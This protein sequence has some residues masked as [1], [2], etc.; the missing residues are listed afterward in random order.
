MKRVL[1]YFLLSTVIMSCNSQSIDL[2]KIEFNKPANSYDLEK[3]KTSDKEEQK[4]HY[5]VQYNAGATSLGLKDNV[6]GV[7]LVLKDNGERV[8]NYVFMGDPI[9]KQ[10][11]YDGIMIDP[12]SGVSL[13]V[14][15]DKIVYMDLTVDYKSK[16]KLFDLLKNKLGEPTEII[17]NESLLSDID[18]DIQTL[19]LEKLPKET[20]VDKENGKLSYP[21]RL[22]WI[23]DNVFYKLELN[24]SGKSIESSLVIISKKAFMDRII[25]G[26]HNP[27]KDPFLSKYL[28]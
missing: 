4:G 6:S 2:S 5:E 11:N 18:L 20:K 15:E 14:Y 3:V 23:K 25:I 13:S 26:Y 24:P 16:F 28:N 1:I 8:T 19:F 7:S 21:E 12:N 22:F 10:L 27:E 17:N 9:T